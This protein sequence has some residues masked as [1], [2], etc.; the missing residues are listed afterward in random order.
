[1][2]AF[3]YGNGQSTEGN[4]G[5]VQADA[6]LTSSRISHG[7]GQEYQVGIPVQRI[8]D[9]PSSSSSFIAIHF[10]LFLPLPAMNRA[11]LY[12]AESKD[13]TRNPLVYSMCYVI[14]LLPLCPSRSRIHFISQCKNIA[15]FASYT[16]IAKSFIRSAL[17]ID[18]CA[19]SRFHILRA[20]NKISEKTL[21]LQSRSV[22]HHEI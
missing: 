8:T 10:S 21:I 15:S 7:F 9:P 17:T 20:S 22:I 3:Y 13:T 2:I 18:Y 5:R 12:F 4:P 19:T 11:F 16:S 6:R 1:M 14:S